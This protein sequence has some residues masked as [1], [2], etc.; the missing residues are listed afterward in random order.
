[1]S[2][3]I[4]IN[5]LNE[6]ALK[7]INKIETN[8]FKIKFSDKTDKLMAGPEILEAF[9]I[10]L[11]GNAAWSMLK[12][13]F[14]ILRKHNIKMNPRET[15]LD[16]I[17]LIYIGGSASNITVIPQGDNSVLI[18]SK[19]SSKQLKINGNFEIT[20]LDQK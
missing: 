9:I 8:Q 14:D 13:L 11:S 20:E 10:G 2:L 15:E 7:E 18:S 5:S 12:A 4:G 17:G 1:M 16:K 6:T 19:K 3:K